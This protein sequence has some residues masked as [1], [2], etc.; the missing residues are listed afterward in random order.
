MLYCVAVQYVKLR[1]VVTSSPVTSWTRVP[2]NATRLGH[3][4]CCI[5]PPP[6]MQG[7]SSAARNVLRFYRPGGTS[8]VYTEPRPALF[9]VRAPWWSRYALGLLACNLF[10]TASAMDLTWKHWSEPIKDESDSKKDKDVPLSPEQYVLRP[11]WQRAGLC[12]IFFGGGVGVAT[13]LFA[14]RIRY[15]KTL[16]VFPRLVNV[17]NVNPN[18]KTKAKTRPKVSAP[19]P[20]PSLVHPAERRIFI[21]SVGHFKNRGL[22]FPLEKCLLEKGRDDSEMVLTVEGERRNWLLNLDG[23]LI[24]GQKVSSV[25][26]VRDAILKHW[27]GGLAS[28]ALL[29]SPV[30]AVDGRWRQ[31][32]IKTT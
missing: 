4:T 12:G 31:G 18:L 20:S 13:V 17:N 11:V 8:H 30:P 25:Y 32:P 28:E 14:L 5:L 19:A 7:L 9:Q 24:D 10:M 29:N 27:K 26:E 3:V 2:A 21:Q 15:I 23:A 1:V 16:D 6:S 22:A